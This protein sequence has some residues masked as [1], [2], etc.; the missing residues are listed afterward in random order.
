MD[1]G[2]GLAQPAD[3]AHPVP[4]QHR[5]EGPVR[6]APG[7]RPALPVMRLGHEGPHFRQRAELRSALHPD[8]RERQAHRQDFRLP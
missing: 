7:V 6:L 2:L 3:G 8:A 4:A 5:A 1:Q